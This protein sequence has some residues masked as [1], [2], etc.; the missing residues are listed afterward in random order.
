[1]SPRPRTAEPSETT[2]TRRLVQ[3]YRSARVSSAWM[4][5][6]TCA[7]PGVYAIDRSRWLSSGVVNSTDSLPPRCPAKMTSSV[8]AT[9]WGVVGADTMATEPLFS[10][11][12]VFKVSDDHRGHAQDPQYR[13]RRRGPDAGP[14]F[15]ARGGAIE[16]QRQQCPAHE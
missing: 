16:M 15:A 14:P 12:S 5:R 4:A 9:C 10:V 6:E 13:S 1:M 7:T 8:S 2:T 3:V 11:F